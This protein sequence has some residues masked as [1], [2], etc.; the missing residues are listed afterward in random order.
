MSLTITK[1]NIAIAASKLGVEPCFIAAVA[2]NESGNKGFLPSGNVVI[3]FE[4]H[5]FL[6]ELKKRKSPQ[7]HIDTAAK[8][9]GTGWATLNAAIALNEEAALASAS[10][11][12]FQIMGF[13]Y[14]ACG[15]T[16]VASFVAAQK[17]S[18]EE[19][20][21]AFVAF[22]RSEGLAPV[23]QRL[24]YAQFARRYNGPGYAANQYDTKLRAAYQRCKAGN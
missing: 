21:A 19:Q 13:N 9:T 18:E 23:M 1:E 16:S 15:F 14:A 8:L 7:S 3:R 6:R 20:L 24:D 12:M 17:R 4:K 11:G 10:W 2:S 5:V 22:V